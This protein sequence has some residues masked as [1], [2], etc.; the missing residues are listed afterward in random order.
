MKVAK[1]VGVVIVF[2]VGYAVGNFLPF[3]GFGTGKQSTTSTSSNLPSVSSAQNQTQLKIKAVTKTGSPVSQLEI[4]VAEKP[5]P[6]PQNGAEI[7]NE[8]GV[9]IFNIEPGNYFVYFNSGN[10]PKNLKEPK[11]ER[12]QIVSGNA[13]EKTITL[14][15]N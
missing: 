12:I 14:E 5:G 9:A 11:P 13:N 6:P 3:N 10:F 8:N 4:D 2:V 15:T 1:I 7:T